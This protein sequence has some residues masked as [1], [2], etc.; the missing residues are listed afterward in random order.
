MVETPPDTVRARLEAAALDA[1]KRRDRVAASAFRA[2]LSALDNAEAVPVDT[3]P[4]AGA[5]EDSALGL[6]AAEA[7]RRHLS[8]QQ[9]CEVVREEID[10]RRQVADSLADLNAEASAELR[11]AADLLEEQ[12]T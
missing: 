9:K 5:I 3:A 11:R 12:L 2:T 10:E 1:R 4:A 7:P 8:E 6:G